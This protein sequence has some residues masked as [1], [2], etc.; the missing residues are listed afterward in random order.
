M[1]SEKFEDVDSKHEHR[2]FKILPK[3]T[4]VTNFRAQ[5]TLVHFATRI[6]DC[7][8]GHNILE[9]YFALIQ[10]RF[11]TSKTNLDILCNKLGIRISKP[12][13]P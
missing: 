5:K 3:T 13:K 4:E 11:T 9:L 1:N 2:F 12:L 10:A 8:P 7:N 6:V